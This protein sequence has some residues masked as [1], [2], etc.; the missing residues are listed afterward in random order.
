MAITYIW[1]LLVNITL[2]KL[3]QSSLNDRAVC[4]YLVLVKLLA[5]HPGSPLQRPRY[6]TSPARE[7]ERKMADNQNF[8]GKTPG[9]YRITAQ[10]WKNPRTI[11]GGNIVEIIV[12]TIMPQYRSTDR[13]VKYSW[14]KWSAHMKFIGKYLWSFS[15]VGTIVIICVGIN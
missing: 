7:E 9:N 11:C 2:V 13:C 14:F 1:L 3:I 5:R 12:H 10:L 6:S 15:V 8:V 4:R